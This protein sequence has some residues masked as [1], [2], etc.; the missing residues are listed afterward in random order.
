MDG[1]VADGT[2][3]PRPLTQRQVVQHA[4]PAV[5]VTTASHLRCKSTNTFISFL[6]FDNLLHILNTIITR[7]IKIAI[8]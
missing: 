1:L 2:L 3:V 4:G 8:I 5:D 7:F 6:F